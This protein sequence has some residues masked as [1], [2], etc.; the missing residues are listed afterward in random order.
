MKNIAKTTSNTI[1]TAR[2]NDPLLY[3]ARTRVKE[4]EPRGM[5]RTT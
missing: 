1:G 3:S 4:T 2:A 5:K